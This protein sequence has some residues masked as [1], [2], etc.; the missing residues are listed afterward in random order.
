MPT[1]KQAIETYEQARNAE[2]KAYNTIRSQ[3]R[4]LWAFE[5]WAKAS[6]IVTMEAVSKEHLI[7][8]AESERTDHR[9][10]PR[11]PST[12]NK[13]KSSVKS[14]CYWCHEMGYCPADV[15]A[16][17][18]IGKNPK[19]D[20][21]YLTETEQNTLLLFLERERSTSDG[22]RD[23]MLARLFL[24]TG[25]RLQEGINLNVGDVDFA[26]QKIRVVT[27][28]GR[29][30]WKYIPQKLARELKEYIELHRQCERRTPDN[31]P[32]FISNRGSRVSERNIQMRFKDAFIMIGKPKASVH[33]LRHSF[34]TSLYR[35]TR[36]LQLV[37]RALGHQNIATTQIYAHLA[38]DDLHQA[39]DENY[40]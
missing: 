23:L 8:F 10:K 37:Q 25:I 30:V 27:K 11:R 33:S 34:G 14:F 22:L 40:R 1:I 19:G 35:Q 18:R 5:A 16:M 36:D 26:T 4:D 7:A 31:V 9:N 12:H 3:M 29:T 32:L 15:S 2:G 20:P 21:I 24:S 28:G 6:G 17:L 39:I 38:D 13:V